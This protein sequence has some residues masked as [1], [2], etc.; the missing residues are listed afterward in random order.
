M[1]SRKDKKRFRVTAR[2]TNA[3]NL[4]HAKFKRG[5]IRQ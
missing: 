1:P 5:G 3:L 2:K 4:R